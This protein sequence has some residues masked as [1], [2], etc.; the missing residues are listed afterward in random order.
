MEKTTCILWAA[1]PAQ[2][3]LGCGLDYS[4][5][6]LLADIK[7]KP[8][9]STG[10]EQ[11]AGISAAPQASRASPRFWDGAALGSISEMLL[12]KPIEKETKPKYLGWESKCWMHSS[13]QAQSAGRKRWRT[14]H[15]LVVGNTSSI[16]SAHEPIT[17][18]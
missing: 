12:Q 9:L 10:T 3:F 8:T 14:R 16:A 15:E 18:A 2:T 11:G 13:C 7:P 6:D 1:S 5:I 4:A 17:C